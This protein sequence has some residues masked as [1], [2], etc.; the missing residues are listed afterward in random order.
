MVRVRVVASAA[1]RSLAFIWLAHF[2]EAGAGE[3]AVISCEQSDKGLVCSRNNTAVDN[4]TEVVVIR[5]QVGRASLES[6]EIS[7]P[8]Y[9]LVIEIPPERAGG[10]MNSIGAI[11]MGD[12]TVGTWG[13]ILGN[14][15]AMGMLLLFCGLIAAFVGHKNKNKINEMQDFV[16]Q[17]MEIAGVT[18]ANSDEEAVSSDEDALYIDVDA[19][20][21]IGLNKMSL[22]A[23]AANSWRKAGKGNDR[24]KGA[25]AKRN[26]MF[27]AFAGVA[28]QM[29]ADP[30]AQEM[31]RH[32]REDAGARMQAKDHNRKVFNPMRDS[33]GTMGASSDP[34][35]NLGEGLLSGGASDFSHSVGNAA[36]ELVD[37]MTK[38]TDNPMVRV[39]TEAAHKKVDSVAGIGDPANT[40]K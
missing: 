4:E 17:G 8:G 12:D 18:H 36:N 10:F 38:G 33:L 40:K 22:A 11:G 14:L 5:L 35:S 34:A 25:A 16:H 31:L 32:A 29:M 3:A 13:I 28:A 9:R 23:N 7:V 1:W 27:S 26:P 24:R 15:A 21:G 19:G 39:I 30:H 6:T 20:S 2:A 37:S